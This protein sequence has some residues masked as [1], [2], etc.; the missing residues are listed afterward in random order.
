VTGIP[1]NESGHV[2]LDGSGSGTLAM[3]PVSGANTWLPG[4][5]SFKASSNTKEASCQVYIGPSATDQYFIDGSLSGSTGDS[6]GRVA[7]YQV[8]THGNTL[9]AV[10]T[11]GD[12]GATGTLQVTGTEVVP[13]GSPFDLSQMPPQPGGGGGCANPIIGGGG[14]LVYPAIHSPNYVLAVSGW[15]IRKDG[16]AQLTGVVL[17]SGSFTGTNFIINS[18]GAFFY[19]GVP[20]TG[21]LVTSIAPAPGNDGLPGGG[22]AYI[23]GAPVSYAGNGA[24]FYATALQALPA[25]G[26][27][28][29]HAASAQGPYANI[30]SIQDS[31][32]GL[33]LSA[34][35]GTD[36]TIAGGHLTYASG[37][38]GNSYATG[39]LT[40]RSPGQTI[41]TAAAVGLTGL[42][43]PVAIGPYRFRA[44][45]L[46]TGSAA[47]GTGNFGFGSPATGAGTLVSFTFINSASGL[48]LKSQIGLGGTQGSFTLSTPAA[49][50]LIIEGVAVFTAAGT[51]AL[52]C[53]LGTLGDNVIILAGSC[54]DL[55]PA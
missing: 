45:L 14:A 38:D 39:R 2:T 13:G 30:G 44:W 1:L 12:A 20:A 6:T 11:G 35:D 37:T 9:R 52:N 10:W 32:S 23:G 19:S 31:T 34:P 41:T 36:V 26:I 46:F 40:L 54:L 50:Q 48:A 33:S 55:D 17:I 28:F 51:F 42:S 22:N 24:D 7:G 27:T 25:A 5:V 47:A 49:Q 15:A 43:A 29:L 3:K 16:T 4:S 21:N 53:G 18:S 8:N